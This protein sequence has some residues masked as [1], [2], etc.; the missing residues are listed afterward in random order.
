MV[1][2]AFLASA[3]LL[4]AFN[5]T[6]TDQFD[7][8][9][10]F[11]AITI[12]WVTAACAM[13]FGFASLRLKFIAADLGYPISFRQSMATISL[14][15][16]GGLLFFQ[17]IGQL[18]ARGA[19]LSGLKIPM[20]GTVLITG[21]ERIG[22]AIVSGFLAVCGALYIFNKI[23]FDATATI[24]PARMLV[25]IA[26]AGSACGFLWRHE[27]IDGF[28]S[29]T[30]DG[31]IRFARSLAIS[32]LVQLSTMIAYVAAAKAV[33]PDSTVY[34]LAAAASLVMFAASIPISLA[35]WGVREL[36][37]IAALSAI[38]VSKEGAFLVA[39]LVGLISIL[40]AF[41]I[42]W[43]SAGFANQQ[44]SLEV[45]SPAISAATQQRR[46]S[47]ALTVITATLIFFQVN[48]PTQASV[49]SVNLADLFA[50]LGGLIVLFSILQRHPPAWRLAGFN[51]HIAACTVAITIALLFGASEIGWT[52]WALINKYTGWFVLLAFLATGSLSST[53]DFDR[54]VRTFVI[55]G[56]AVIAFS[57][58][59]MMGSVL[60]IAAYNPFFVGFSQN[61]NAFAF[62]CLMVL[63]GALVV[64]ANRELFIAMALAGLWLTLSRAG[65]AT[66]IVVIATAA[67]F[68]RGSVRPIL[69]GI[70]GAFVIVAAVTSLLTLSGAAC[71]IRSY[72]NCVP[73]P[74]FVESDPSIG[75]HTL[76]AKKAFA[77]FLNH[78]LFGAGLGVFIHDWKGSYP[79]VIHSTPLWLLAEFGLI[80]TLVFFVPIVR[81]FAQEAR[82]FRT[83][84]VAGHLLILIITALS[85]MSILHEIFYQ[86]TFWFLLGV[87][88]I[89]RTGDQ[90]A[91][92]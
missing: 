25:G 11:S 79:L 76:I 66:G 20:A 24:N 80:G 42:A 31:I 27:I 33:A 92:R 47:Q 72:T 81:I 53:L 87:A 43:V 26:I 8:M 83:N 37:A 6:A 54:I 71:D 55:T 15:Q 10:K 46:L 38:G 78:P 35:G 75:E 34:E 62:Q 70:I 91:D 28:A 61:T 73:L 48:L 56:C 57:I 12:A 52:Q 30:R 36:S 84:D 2:F 58:T 69:I 68:V 63:C 65:I 17:L 67:T 1:T 16:V 82:S 74:T 32:L 13:G 88:L 44:Q 7:A 21:V 3:L 39:V 5:S 51:I 90:R 86:R 41:V 64:K 22:A 60:G 50:V 19:Y 77:M 18:V 85:A 49:I 89:L 45:K 9:A 23:G 40:V 14:G 4:V 59:E 29:I